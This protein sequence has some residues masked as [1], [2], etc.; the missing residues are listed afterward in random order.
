[1]NYTMNAFYKRRE[2][3]SM[4]NSLEA[5]CYYKNLLPDTIDCFDPSVSEKLKNVIN[6]TAEILLNLITL[7]KII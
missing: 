2:S 7:R 6:N 5:Y 3:V 4:C 1:M